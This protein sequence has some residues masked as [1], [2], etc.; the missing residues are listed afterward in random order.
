MLVAPKNTSGFKE[1]AAEIEA[2]KIQEFYSTEDAPL[3]NAT[4]VS[5]ASVKRAT[6]ATIKELG[7]EVKTEFTSND[8]LDI[9]ASAA[10][11]STPIGVAAPLSGTTWLRFHEG[12]LKGHTLLKHVGQSDAALLARLARQRWIKGAS[13]YINEAV[14]AQ[15]I[16]KTIATSRS[17]VT[18]WLK[19]AK[20]G[21]RLRLSYSGKEVVGRTALKG[22]TAVQNSTNART[23]LQSNGKGGYHVHTSFPE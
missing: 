7:Y 20:A 15:V 19:K 22:K 16:S 4:E 18:A 8:A 1:A 13:T 14:A 10:S 12:L 21:D 23:I 17:T 6:D 9:F 11:F 3:E 5:A 2:E